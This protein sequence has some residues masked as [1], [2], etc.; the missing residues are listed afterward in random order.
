MRIGSRGEL[1]LLQG[2]YNSIDRG[3]GI[4][5]GSLVAL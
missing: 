4:G 1:N 2:S 5:I 3:I